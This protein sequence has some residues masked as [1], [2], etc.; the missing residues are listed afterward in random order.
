[1]V[2]FNIH[3]AYH[4]HFRWRWPTK[5]SADTGRCGKWIDSSGC[6]GHHPD[7]SYAKAINERLSTSVVDASGWLERGCGNGIYGMDFPSENLVSIKCFSLIWKHCSLNA[8]SLKF[9]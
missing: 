8:Q 3:C 6:S 9:I 4:H 7:C 2:Y 1:M 5:A